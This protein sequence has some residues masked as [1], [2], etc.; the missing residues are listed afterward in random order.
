MAFVGADSGQGGAQE[1]GGRF[2]GEAA[3]TAQ[4]DDIELAVGQ[5]ADRGEQLEGFGELVGVGGGVGEVLQDDGVEGGAAEF[6]PTITVGGRAMT[7]ARKTFQAYR[8]V[9]WLARASFQDSQ[10]RLNVSSTASS[11][12]SSSR[13]TWA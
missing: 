8:R 11:R 10:R 12:W 3:Q 7:V 4:D 9:S 13:K 2:V 6:G 5:A 1:G